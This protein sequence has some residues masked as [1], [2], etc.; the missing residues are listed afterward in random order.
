MNRRTLL[1]LVGRAGGTA[2]VLTT[3]K[4]MGLLHS[5]ATVSERPNLPK[6]SGDGIKVA[7]LGAGIAGMTAAYELSQAGYDCTILE[8]RDRAGGRCWTIRGGDT[9]R[10]L[11]SEQSCSFESADYLYMNPGAA[12]IPHHHQGILGYCKEFGV[13][14]QV[15]VN[16]NRA[17]Y[18]QDDNA[19]EGRPILNRRVVSDSRGYITELLAKAISQNALEQQVSAEDRERILKMIQNFGDLDDDLSYKG[20]GRAG[21]TEPPATG[22]KSGITYPSINFSELLQSDF[23]E[24]KMNFSESYTQSATMLEPVGGMDKIAQ[25]FEQRVGDSIIYNA[26]VKQIRKT[27]SGVRVVYVDR[28]SD[29]EE[30]L[31]ANFTICTIPLSVLDTLDTDFAPKYQEAIAVG[32]NSY[33]RAVKHG[34]Q[35]KRRFWEEE[36]HIYGGISWTSR[37]ITQIW[38]PTSGFHQPTGIVIGAYIWDNEIGDPIADMPIAQRLQKAVEDGLAIHPNYEEELNLDTGVSVAW[39]KIPYSM[40]GWMDWSEEARETAYA[41]LLEPDES[42]YFAGE[43]M[44]YLTGW[45]E[46]SVLSAHDAIRGISVQLQAMKA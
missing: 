17:C 28:T 34:F 41:T 2:A 37:D 13:P 44:S 1:R 5:A 46:G 30:A 43:H 31:E 16:E 33:I 11:D 20:S 21:Y 15:I 29:D 18:L 8:A 14:L 42:I 26:E 38:Y 40:G 35:A 9:I 4:A 6:G 10:E 36:D 22:L 19:F 27:E 39:G 45:Q 25:A 7:I 32:A 24:F 12:R 23:W 3:M